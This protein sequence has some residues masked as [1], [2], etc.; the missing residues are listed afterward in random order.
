[1]VWNKQAHR[2]EPTPVDSTRFGAVYNTNLK[3]LG[4]LELTQNSNFLTD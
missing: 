1:M 3:L 2:Y 4:T